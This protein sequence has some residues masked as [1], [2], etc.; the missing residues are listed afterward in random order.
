MSNKKC[1]G[2]SCGFARPKS[3]NYHGFSGASKIFLF[4]FTMPLDGKRGWNMDKPAIWLLNAKIPRTAQF[5]ANP[6]CS[7]WKSGCGEFDVFE[8]LDAGNMRAKSTLHVGPEGGKQRAGCS[9]FFER[10]VN[11]PIKVAVVLD[12]ATSTAHI[13]ILDDKTDFPA[14]LSNAQTKEFTSIKSG[15]DHSEFKLS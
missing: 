1:E 7:C 5:P 8:V 9:D 14:S 6:E 10:P 2:D 3:V 4:E 15:P 12:A 11:K 13:Q